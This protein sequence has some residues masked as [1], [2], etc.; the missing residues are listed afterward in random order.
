MCDFSGRL[1]AWLDNELTENEAAVIGGHV[2][3]CAEC[4][5]RVK[6]YE[7]AGSM[8]DAYCGA[9]MTMASKANHAR[10]RWIP[11]LAGAAATA[12]IAALLLIF[13]PAPVEQLPLHRSAGS[14]PPAIVAKASL[15]PVKRLRRRASSRAQ[16]SAQVQ[17]AN[18]PT[19]AP[20]IQISIPA[21]EM[22]PPGAVPEGVNFVADLSV[23]VDGSA[24]QL[25]LRP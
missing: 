25:H 7:A 10:P 6:S 13:L 12:T 16:T 22:F 23:A 4:R 5:S 17:R 21:D 2:R 11:V 8:F 24:Q 1:I 18:W 14:P 19:G 20:A 3:D 9:V 15:A